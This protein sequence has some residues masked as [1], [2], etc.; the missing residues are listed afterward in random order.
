MR[1]SKLIVC[2]VMTIFVW[3]WLVGFLAPSVRADDT[4]ARFEGGI[5]VIPVSSG[6]GQDPTAT[7]VNRNIVRGVQPAGQ[8][9]VIKKLEA[10]VK[11]NGDIAVQGEG[12]VLGGGNNIGRA[13][14]Q[15]VLAT[16]I[17]EA[18]PP[19]T[20]HNSDPEGVPLDPN[21]DF[22]IEDVLTPPPPLDCASPVLLI[23]N[24]ANLNWFA[25]GI[26]SQE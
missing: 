1:R 21:G 20:E 23:R 10:T 5:G 24:A 12:L 6:V 15:R 13:T 9:W 11:L 8:I 14:G 4:L 18:A 25:A 26:L 3:A 2:A 16:L 7:T 17:C 19:F 22:H